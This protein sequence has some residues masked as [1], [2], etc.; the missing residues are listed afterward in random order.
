MFASEHRHIWFSASRQPA[1]MR[2]CFKGVQIIDAFPFL[3]L[4]A[5]CQLCRPMMSSVASVIMRPCFKGMQNILATLSYYI[6]SR[7]EIVPTCDVRCRFQVLWWEATARLWCSVDLS[8]VWL[9]RR[10]H[11]RNLIIISRVSF[12][13]MHTCT[14]RCRFHVRSWEDTACLWCTIV[15]SCV[16]IMAVPSWG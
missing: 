2:A 5:V 12:K 4:E 6:L 11:E 10:F 8:L 14:V 15:V 7:Y 1:I 13:I 16:I 9:W 3:Q